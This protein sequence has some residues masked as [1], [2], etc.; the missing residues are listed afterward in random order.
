MVDINPFLQANNLYANEKELVYH[1]ALF[2]RQHYPHFKI[3]FEVKN[4]YI[5]R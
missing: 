4:I 5:R 2:L 3:Y 1:F